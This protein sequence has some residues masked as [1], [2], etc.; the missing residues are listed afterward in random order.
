MDERIVQAVKQLRRYLVPPPDRDG[1]VLRPDSAIQGFI[2]S[3]LV[4]FQGQRLHNL[5]GHPASLPPGK[6]LHLV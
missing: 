2:L 6:I 5:S 4:T 1:R 3:G